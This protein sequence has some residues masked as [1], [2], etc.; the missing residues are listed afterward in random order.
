[1]ISE[2][3][4]KCQYPVFLE[5]F[6]KLFFILFFPYMLDG[7]M[8][9]F[10]TAKMGKWLVAVTAGNA[11]Y[12]R[13]VE[14]LFTLVTALRQ[15]VKIVF[16]ETLNRFLFIFKTYFLVLTSVYFFNSRVIRRR[17]SGT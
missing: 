9:R 7:V 16:N 4:E 8:L 14:N 17:K 3:S 11:W 5:T 6:L 2:K 13:L 1:M 15:K 10:V 12:E